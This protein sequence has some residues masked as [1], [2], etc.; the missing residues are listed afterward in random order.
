MII[1]AGPT[2]LS[3][4]GV[5]PP[6]DGV[7]RRWRF[8]VAIAVAL[9]DARKNLSNSPSPSSRLG[10]LFLPFGRNSVIRSLGSNLLRRPVELGSI[11]PHA[12][13]NDRELTRDR[14]LGL[15]EPVALGEPYPP[16]LHGGP[17][18]HNP[19]C[20]KQITS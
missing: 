10:R 6:H 11:D 7:R 9:S 1:L 18:Q 2:V 4:V 15:A 3:A 12:M 17:R 5:N 19:G 20:F 16:S 13:Q 14:N 8:N